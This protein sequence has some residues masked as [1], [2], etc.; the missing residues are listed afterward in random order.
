MNQK[1]NFFYFSNENN[2]KNKQAAKG[3]PVTPK[4]LVNA[5]ETLIHVCVFS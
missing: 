4:L 5:D 2:K 1:M 3:K